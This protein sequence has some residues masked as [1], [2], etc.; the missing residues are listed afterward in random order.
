[1][2]VLLNFQWVTSLSKGVEDPVSNLILTNEKIWFGV[3]TLKYIIYWLIYYL[4]VTSAISTRDFC[5]L[6]VNRLFIFREK[7][8]LSVVT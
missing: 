4:K 7:G 5:T 3:Y 8:P 1:M 2:Y 6:W